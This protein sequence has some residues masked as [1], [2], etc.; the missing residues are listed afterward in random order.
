MESLFSLNHNPNKK[1]IKS[2][3]ISNDRLS[4]DKYKII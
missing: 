4:L 2:Y 3:K 1:A